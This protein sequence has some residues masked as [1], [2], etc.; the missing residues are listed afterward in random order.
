MGYWLMRASEFLPEHE[1][2]WSRTGGTMKLKWRCTSGAK[3]GRIVPD[4]KGCSTP[5]DT[6]K[7][8]AMTLTR[9]KTGARQAVRTKKTKKLN[10]TTKL[11]T[12]LNKPKR[13]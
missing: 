2:I 3:R 5:V 8:H 10:P 7:R 4:I 13:R 12:R 6:K 1:I 9:A 11:L